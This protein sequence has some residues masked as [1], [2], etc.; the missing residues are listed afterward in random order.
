VDDAEGVRSGHALCN[1]PGEV[2]RLPCGQ[3]TAVEYRPEAF[4]VDQ[5]GDHVGAPVFVLADVINRD[6]IG[7]VQRPERAGLLFEAGA[8]T[9]VRGQSEGQHLDRDHSVQSLIRSTPYLAHA[10]LAQLI[11]NFVAR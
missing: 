5:F 7:V 3:R 10:S 2:D 8:E 6:D 4:A 1:L 11:N 9:G